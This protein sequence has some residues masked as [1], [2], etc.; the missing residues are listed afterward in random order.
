MKK[1]FIFI[2][3]L[4]SF[5]AKSQTEKQKIEDTKKWFDNFIV[6][7]CIS[8]NYW[9]RGYKIKDES[10]KFW[11][12]K[13]PISSNNMEILEDFIGKYSKEQDGNDTILNNCL[14]IKESG[15]YKLLIEKIIKKDLVL[16]EAKYNLPKF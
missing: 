14:K 10:V 7:K 9:K 16:K 11:N 3:F 2:C 12:E 4:F 13:T 6:C 15:Q 1:K 8:Y 5:Y